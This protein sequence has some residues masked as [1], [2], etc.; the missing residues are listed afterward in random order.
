MT[1]KAELDLDALVAEF[2]NPDKAEDYECRYKLLEEKR[3]QLLDFRSRDI[4][5]HK[6]TVANSV[7]K[8]AKFFLDLEYNA[9]H[10]NSGPLPDGK[11]REH[12]EAMEAAFREAVHDCA[13]T[14]TL[15]D[16][17][18]SFGLLLKSLA[19]ISE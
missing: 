16:V 6:Q 13:E 12:R 17:E 10:L 3:E 2:R 19:T 14:I 7:V 4:A 15:D 18:N 5:H 1:T 9:W 11:K 8:L